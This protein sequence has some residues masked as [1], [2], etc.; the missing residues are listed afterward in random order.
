MYRYRKSLDSI[1]AMAYDRPDGIR[2]VTAYKDLLPE[3]LIKC[4]IYGNT[5]NC[6]NHWIDQEL[7]VWLGIINDVR[8]KPKNRRLKARDLYQYLFT[9]FGDSKVDASIALRIFKTTNYRTKK[10]PDFELNQT[11]IDVV[12]DVFQDTI[13]K[14]I[15]IFVTDNTYTQEN[16]K[17]LIEP[18]LLKAH[19][20]YVQSIN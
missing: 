1:F 2:I 4:I 10:Y 15:P 18:M 11:L 5:L 12:Y 9:K 3:H 7:C 14:L 13:K 16:F 20:T 6:W 19:N 8:L 17:Q